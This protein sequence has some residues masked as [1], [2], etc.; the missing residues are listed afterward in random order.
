MLLRE[1]LQETKVLPLS[2]ISRGAG[3]MERAILH[4][5]KNQT[6]RGASKISQ[7][8]STQQG[9]WYSSPAN[10]KWQKITL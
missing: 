3:C 7:S 2:K 8:F 1:K 6:Q 5:L 4:Q 10:P 9:L